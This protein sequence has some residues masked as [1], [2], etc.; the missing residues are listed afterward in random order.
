MLAY[1][2]LSIVA[3]IGCS[4]YHPR[5]RADV[6]KVPVK[7]PYNLNSHRTVLA[8]PLRLDETEETADVRWKIRK[9]VHPAIT[10]RFGQVNL[11]PHVN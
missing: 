1:E 11:Q 10:G 9:D 8:V 3:E 7:T 6:M 2:S 4:G 5:R